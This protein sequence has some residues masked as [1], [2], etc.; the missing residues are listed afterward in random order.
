MLILEITIT[1]AHEGI[2]RHYEFQTLRL[3][4]RVLLQLVGR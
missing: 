2:K 1:A 4:F 3:Q